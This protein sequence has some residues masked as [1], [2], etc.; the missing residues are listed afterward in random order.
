MQSKYTTQRT[1]NNH[2]V[3]YFVKPDFKIDN[4]NE[5]RKLERQVEDELHNELRQTCFREKNYSELNKLR[6]CLAIL[7]VVS[8][9]YKF[10]K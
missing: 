1:T 5:L 8:F 6:I 3:S 10:W 2:H 7:F 4:Y 9:L